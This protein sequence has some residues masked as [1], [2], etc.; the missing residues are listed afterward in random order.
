VEKHTEQEDQNPSS[1]ERIESEEWF[2]DA[3]V[4]ERIESKEFYDEA[5]A[6]EKVD[7]ETVLD[8]A[9]VVF[10]V[11][12]DPANPFAWGRLILKL[13]RAWRDRKRK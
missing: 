6:V 9:E 2:T 1:K 5:K 13:W 12:A 3:R 7:P 11:V 4:I 8:N 10:D